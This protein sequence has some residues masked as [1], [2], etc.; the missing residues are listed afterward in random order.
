MLK[1]QNSPSHASKVHEPWTSRCSRWIEKRQRNQRLNCQ[2]LWLKEKARELKKKSN[3]VSLP[4]LKPLCGSRQT[5]KIFKKW[6]YQTTW[7]ASWEICMQVKKQQ[8]ELEMEQR[9]CSKLGK[10]YDKYVYCHPAYLTYMQSTMWNAGLGEQH[11]VPGG[12]WGQEEKGMT[13]DEMAGWHHWLDGRWV[14][15]NS[16][17]WWWTGRPGVLRFMGSQRFGHHWV[18]EVNWTSYQVYIF[19]PVLQMKNFTSY[20][21]SC[22]KS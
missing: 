8:L 6:E 20:N 21:S 17:S 14:W 7:P 18:T 9:A 19:I 11:S 4:M 22:L 12:I 13:E 16:R 5:G 15:V 2:H 3:S 1:I 10:E